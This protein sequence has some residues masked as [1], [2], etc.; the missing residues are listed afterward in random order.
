MKVRQ[1]AVWILGKIADPKAI[2]HIIKM[3]EDEELEVWRSVPWSVSQFG[4]LVPV[5][6][7]L[8]YLQSDVIELKRRAI[9]YFIY[10]QDDR[11]L[12]II[13]DYLLDDDEDV[14]SLSIVA[15]MKY[16]RDKVI[17]AV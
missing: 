6:P 15:M 3:I 13:F 7:F 2:N 1:N 5:E 8:E 12:N 10:F 4:D 11:A 14:V 17:P 9:R 16:E